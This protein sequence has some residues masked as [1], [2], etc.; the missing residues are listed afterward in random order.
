MTYNINLIFISFFQ[1]IPHF[2]TLKMQG[3]IRG[4]T[5]PLKL[6]KNMI[7]WHKIVIF[8]TKYPKYFH[9]SIRSA[10]FF[11]SAPPP[12]NL[13][14]RIHPWNE[15]EKSLA[16]H[17]TPSP[18]LEG[19]L[20]LNLNNLVYLNTSEYILPP[21]LEGYLILSLNNLVHLSTSEYIPPPYLEGT[22][23]WASIIWYTSIP[24]NISY[25]LI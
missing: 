13:K 3:R 14:S 16:H 19:Y 7:F 6:E 2:E 17:N 9:T 24:Q 22:S 23:S 18:Y 5:P 1:D 20:I 25:L 8:H 15:F 21:Y 11:L 10:Q 12:P 4:A